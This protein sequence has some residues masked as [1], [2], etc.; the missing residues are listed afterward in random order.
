MNITERIRTY[1]TPTPINVT[2]DEKN[3]LGQT[4]DIENL[5]AANKKLVFKTIIDK[6]IMH[7]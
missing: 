5:K 2:I 3:N 4:L 6:Q 1:W 7:V